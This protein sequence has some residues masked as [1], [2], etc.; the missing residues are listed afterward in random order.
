MNVW[1]NI[2][3]RALA[4][5]SVEG[6]VNIPKVRHTN[7]ALYRSAGYEQENGTFDCQKG[8][9]T[10]QASEWTIQKEGGHPNAG[11]YL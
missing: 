8:S 1:Y 4:H 7:T 6:D 3:R 11:R 10:E 9:N 5:K 2:Q